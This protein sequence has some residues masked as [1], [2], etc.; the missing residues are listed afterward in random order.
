MVKKI[1]VVVG[2]FLV[3]AL[4]LCFSW[5][6]RGEIRDQP[7]GMKREYVIRSVESGPDEA[8]G[9]RFYDPAVFTTWTE[10]SLLDG[11]P[12][13]VHHREERTRE[14]DRIFWKFFV[15]P[16]SL[17]LLVSEKKIETREGLPVLESRDYYQNSPRPYPPRTFHFQMIPFVVQHL[18]V[19]APTRINLVFGPEMSPWEVTLIPDGQ[20]TIR[21]PAGSFTCLRLKM[22]YG[23]DI[24]PPIFKYVPSAL[25][26]RF[27]S[28][29]LI[30]VQKDPPHALVRYQ[31]K[32]SGFASPAKAHDLAR[33][34]EP[35]QERPPAGD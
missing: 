4:A 24:L 20:E 9:R 6:G 2:G 31:G 12:V 11:L 3:M 10:S 26:D 32:L 5:P 19:S 33:I 35:D 22:V 29:Y 1:S 34:V 30:W 23:R 18:R 25:V 8:A 7:D 15:E 27:L 21:V 17:K 14:G 13:L 28:D 16:G